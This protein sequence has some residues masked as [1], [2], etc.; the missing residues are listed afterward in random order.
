MGG[1]QQV[2]PR[3]GRAFSIRTVDRLQKEHLVGCLAEGVGEFYYLLPADSAKDSCMVQT[4]L[5]HSFDLV[6]AELKR[7]GRQMPR[8]L[9]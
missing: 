1:N 5:A 9:S 2:F 7:R 4:V 3:R 6:A 8:Q